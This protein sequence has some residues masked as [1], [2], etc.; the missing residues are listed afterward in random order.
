M[1]NIVLI[2]VL[3]SQ[4]I[5][6]QYPGDDIVRQGVHLFYNYETDSAVA[7]L[8]TARVSYPNH[9][10]VHLTWAS[11]RWL[12][13]QTRLDIQSTYTYLMQD[14]DEIIPVYDRLIDSFPNDP[15][16]RLYL[17][18]AKGLKA[19]VHLG[20]KEW[21]STLVAAYSGFSIIRDVAKRNP[22]IPDTQLPIGIVEYY[23]SLS[24]PVIRWSASL[25][26]LE[27]TAEAGLEKIKNAADNGEWSWIEASSI[28]AFLNL[29][30]E[31]RPDTG[32][33]Y[34]KKLIRHFPR[35]YYFNIM[36]VDGLLR[37]GAD[38]AARIHLQKLEHDL[39]SLTQIQQSWY[40]P[41]WMYEMAYASFLEKDDDTALELVMAAIDNYQAELDIVLANAYLLLG[42]IEDRAGN[43]EAAVAAY[44]TCVN[45]GNYAHAISEARLFLE[46]PFDG[47][48]HDN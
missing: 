44:S 9:P 1:K 46:T 39:S 3:C 5:L 30:V 36:Y 19:R 25:F 18:S 34:A 31:N 41:Y 11:A 37:T 13:N 33:V 43:R 47:Q 14:L 35:N 8:T 10:A 23:A 7:I 48:E 12:N 6:S 45:L 16:Y 24:N 2:L 17:G 29:W 22:D 26:G 15:Q 40:R 28:Y 21:F 38:D 4:F 27:T 32:L 20:R 42:M